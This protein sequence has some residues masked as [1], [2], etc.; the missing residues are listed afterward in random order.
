MPDVSWE[1]RLVVDRCIFP[2]V[3]TSVT[4][5][6]YFFQAVIVFLSPSLPLFPV[7]C[8]FKAPWKSDCLYGQ[9]YLLIQAIFCV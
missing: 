4:K 6:L 3:E 8:L 2:C 1:G 7:F 5:T 9:T